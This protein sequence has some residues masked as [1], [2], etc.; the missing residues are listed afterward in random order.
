MSKDL[1][2]RDFIKGAVVT[3][4]GLIGAVIGI[5]SI[6][7]LLSP[8]VRA[9]EDTEIIDLGALAKYPIGIPTRFDSVQTKVNGWERTATTYGLFVVRR[10]ET[11]VRVFQTF[12]HI[13]V[14]ACPGVQIRSIM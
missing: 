6:A 10:S 4:G 13:W 1:S 7:Y 3:I 8:G 11:E 12:V 2:R 9:Q 14:V 5:P